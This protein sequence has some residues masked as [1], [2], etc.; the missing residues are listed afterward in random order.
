MKQLQTVTDAYLNGQYTASDFA[1]T[2]AVVIARMSEQDTDTL[3][4]LISY[5]ELPQPDTGRISDD[6]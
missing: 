3:A 6:A 5:G 4:F 2:I 1:V